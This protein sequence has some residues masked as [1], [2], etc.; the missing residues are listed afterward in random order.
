VFHLSGTTADVRLVHAVLRYGGVRLEAVSVLRR[1]GEGSYP[2]PEFFLLRRPGRPTRFTDIVIKFI[3][4]YVLR[5]KL[6]KLIY[7]K[8]FIYLLKNYELS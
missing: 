2:R 3:L 7:H 5:A 6:R 1:Y 8:I 4:R